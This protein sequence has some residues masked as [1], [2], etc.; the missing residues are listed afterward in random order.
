MGVISTVKDYFAKRKLE[1]NTTEVMEKFHVDFKELTGSIEFDL[2][3][4]KA[5]RAKLITDLALKVKSGEIDLGGTEDERQDYPLAVLENYFIDNPRILSIIENIRGQRILTEMMNEF[6]EEVPD[7]ARIEEKVVA[8]M[9]KYRPDGRNPD[10]SPYTSVD[11]FAMMVD[12]IQEYTDDPE[13]ASDQKYVVKSV[14]ENNTI[15]RIEE[16]KGP[17]AKLRI[18]DEYIH[19]FLFG[20]IQDQDVVIRR[21][22]GEDFA[23]NR[24]DPIEVEM[25]RIYGDEEDQK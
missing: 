23:K 13:L 5:K 11:K 22:S 10:I 8:F 9:R 17:A 6:Y 15:R 18:Y 21:F 20:D 24:V 7:L 2:E 12:L 25:K 4:R 19:Q 14:Y 3:V 16:A 1:K